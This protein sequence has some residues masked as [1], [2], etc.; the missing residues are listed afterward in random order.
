MNA[1][2]TEHMDLQSHEGRIVIRHLNSELAW[3]ITLLSQKCLQ[4]LGE[5]KCAMS[6]FMFRNEYSIVLTQFNVKTR[7]V[8]ILV[9]VS[10]NFQSNRS[11]NRRRAIMTVTKQQPT[12][13]DF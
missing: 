6:L 11:G 5:P 9:A 10:G 4:N 3:L 7:C 8:I 1:V 2:E 12:A 13:A